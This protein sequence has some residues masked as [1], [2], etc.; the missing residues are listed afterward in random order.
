MVQ[1]LKNPPAMPEAW[2]LFLGCEDPLEKGKATN[3]SILALE[4]SLDCIV[5]MLIHTLAGLKTGV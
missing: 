1:L 4:N 3:S 2:V 5:N